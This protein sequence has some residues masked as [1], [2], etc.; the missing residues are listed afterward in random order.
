MRSVATVPYNLPYNP[1]QGSEK[2]RRAARNGLGLFF[3]LAAVGAGC[4]GRA[5]APPATP[6]NVLIVT[7]DTLRADRIG[8]YG[9][10]NVATPAID[11]L[12]REGAWVPNATVHA[13]LTRP[14]HA[15]LF[16]GRY[17]A[18]HGLRDNVS[19]PLAGDV[20]LLAE[21][22][23]KDGYATAAFVASV[24]LDRQSGLDRGF[25]L[26]SDAM[27]PGADRK[28]GD[29]VVAEAV[30][31]LKGKSRFFAWVHLYDPHA[32]YV[33]PGRYA[34]EYA[35]RPYDGTVAWSDELVG[36]LVEALRASG[37]LDST[38]VVVTSD[39]G[40]SLGEHGEDVHGYFV[41]EATLR[42]PLVMRGPGI[43]PGTQIGGLVRTIDL[44][45]TI[46]DLFAYPREV[47]SGR[48]IAGALANGTPAGDEPSFA[49]SLTP[50]LHYGWSD[51]RAVNDGR[52]KYILAP[53][54]ELYDLQNDPNELRNLVDAEPARATALRHAIE[55]RLRAESESLRNNPSAVAVPPELRERLGALGYLG[56]GPPVSPKPDSAKKGRA[57]AEDPKDK[58]AEYKA[59]STAMQD[60]LVAI[61]AGDHARA[62]SHLQPLA[63][64]GVDTF[65]VHLY[66]GRAYDGA[67]RPRE[68]AAEYRK[69]AERLPGDA[70]T[71]RALGASLVA[72]GNSAAAVPAF[73]KLVSLRPKD[74]VARMQLGEA[75]RDLG[76]DQ[77]AV[78]AITT[79]LSLD[80]QPAQYWN[81]LGTVLGASGNVGDAAGAFAQ[82]AE[83]DPANGM[84]VYN[85]ALA[86]PHLGRRDEAAAQFKRAA[87]LGYRQGR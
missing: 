83:R 19:P 81:S 42:V 22:F 64:K 28:P 3:W 85:R 35:G 20:P 70:E 68:A 71:W 69:A 36:R 40:E 60:G 25:G 72:A 5:P 17:P 44:Y 54:P 45:P 18:E 1:L 82:A 87:E 14:S 12:A 47:V 2:V 21:R 56:T 59:L 73:E 23:W 62:I 26:Y 6:A 75:L 29:A 41:Y 86:L 67:G 66:L 46:L 84:Y 37:T 32:P 48:S 76:R 4:A 38:V 80:P 15:S 78:T 27:P 77:E 65:E 50:L 52:W 55:P 39:H 74:A 24:V 57:E 58:L 79:A 11:R 43:K 9:A 13:P 63:A 53:K 51:L 33:P 34:S 7:I 61:R 31:W 49:E 16:T 8:V 30:D 10:R